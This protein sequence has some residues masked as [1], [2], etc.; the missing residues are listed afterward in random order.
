M[1]IRSSAEKSVI[2][3]PLSSVKDQLRRT[4]NALKR[5]VGIDRGLDLD[6]VPPCEPPAELGPDR[7][8]HAGFF[9]ERPACE[10]V[11]VRAAPEGRAMF[12]GDQLAMLSF[13]RTGGARISA[14]V[15]YWMIRD[16]PVSYTVPLFDLVP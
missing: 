2:V 7:K 11:K 5:L 14:E 9:P 6:S 3:S 4:E 10:V 13:R 8:L 12:R 16:K 15:V 1:K